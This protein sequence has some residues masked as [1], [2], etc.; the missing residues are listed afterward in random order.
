LRLA[1]D[2]LP[3][4]IDLGDLSRARGEEVE[5]EKY[6]RRAVVVAPEDATA[7]YAL[8]LSL[9][10]QKRTDEAMQALARARALGS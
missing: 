10:R 4:L 7:W 6:L 5:A 2:F 1:P 8:G 9:V 3:A